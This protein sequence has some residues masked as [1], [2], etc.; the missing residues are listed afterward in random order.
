MNSFEN[1]YSSFAPHK[2]PVEDMENN[3]AMPNSKEDKPKKGLSD[4]TNIL[5]SS[6]LTNPLKSRQKSIEN[7]SDNSRLSMEILNVHHEVMNKIRNV[8]S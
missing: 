4:L 3:P 2:L 8:N 7:N 1:T 6:K 5:K